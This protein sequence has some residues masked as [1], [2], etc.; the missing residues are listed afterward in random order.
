[1]TIYIYNIHSLWIQPYLLRKWDWG[2]ILVSKYLL[3]HP[4]GNSIN[5]YYSRCKYTHLTYPPKTSKNIQKHPKTIELT[6]SYLL[7]IPQP[8][9]L[10]KLQL[11]RSW[12]CFPIFHCDIC[13]IA[14]SSRLFLGN[15][16]ANSFHAQL[17]SIQLLYR[18]SLA[19]GNQATYRIYTSS[20]T[21][22]MWMEQTWTIK[23]V[24]IKYD[25]LYIYISIYV[26]IQN[27]KIIYVYVYIY[28]C[29]HVNI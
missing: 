10:V 28:I 3:R 29:I 9:L 18:W 27:K 24:P 23:C 8:Q 4:R 19:I 16:S 22:K 12:W 15:S 6:Q 1:M 7:S 11:M 2:R 21:S 13:D 14:A 5:T 25:I 20:R 17:F 26:Y